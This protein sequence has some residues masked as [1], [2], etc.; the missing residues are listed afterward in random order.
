MKKIVISKWSYTFVAPLLFLQEDYKAIF[1]VYVTLKYF[2]IIFEDFPRKKQEITRKRGLPLT[3]M[4]FLEKAGELL[5]RSNNILVI[6]FYY[7]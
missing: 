6:G 4:L 1:A 5:Y 7:F 2:I 3:A